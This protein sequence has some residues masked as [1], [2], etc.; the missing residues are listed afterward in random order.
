MDHDR[1]TPDGGFVMVRQVSKRRHGG[2]P[3]RRGK[4]WA[5]DDWPVYIAF[6]PAALASAAIAITAAIAL[7]TAGSWPQK[8]DAAGLKATPQADDYVEGL[9]R[10]GIAKLPRQEPTGTVRSGSRGGPLPVTQLARGCVL[11]G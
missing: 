3:A 2:S 6:L 9:A 11:L 7:G 4:H 8:P 1:G 10:L 5:A